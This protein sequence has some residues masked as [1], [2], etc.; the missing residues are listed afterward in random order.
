[1]TVYM[2]LHD[3]I[4]RFGLEL[5]AVGRAPRL[6]VLSVET[7]LFDRIR[8][9]QAV[10]E[11][12]SKWR[13]RAD[14]RDSG[15]YSVVDGIVRFRGRLWV[16]AGIKRDIARFVSECLTCQQVKAEHQRPAGLLK[17]L[18]IPKWKWD[19]ITMDFVVGLPRTVRG[20]NSIWVIVDHLT[21]SAH[22]LPVGRISL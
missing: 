22:F 21:K 2:P 10:D 9:A 13:H 20:S 12:L 11:Q 16:P 15:L 5:Y 19:N 8:V 18:P 1:M 7:S 14:E 4:Q 17:P 3:E 6:P